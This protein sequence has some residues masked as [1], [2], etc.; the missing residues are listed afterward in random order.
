MTIDTARQPKGIPSGGQFAATAHAEPDV[1]LAGRPEKPKTVMDRYLDREA[2]QNRRWRLQQQMERLDKIQ[3]AHSLRSVAA[4]LLARYPDAATL[5][6]GEDP[7]GHDPYVPVSLANKD[8]A[9]LELTRDNDEWMFEEMVQHG[10]DVRELVA[11]LD[12]R[13]DD[14]AKDIGHVHGT[15]TRQSK[16]IDIDLRAALA[17]PD[18]F[19]AEE[20]DPRT[21][22]LSLDEQT[23]LVEA[24]NHGVIAMEDILD[25]NNSFDEHRQFEVLENLKDRVNTLLTVKKQAD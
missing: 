3:A 18:P 23:D 11:D 13:S 12:Y 14:W 25:D 2:V 8:G 24:A 16:M 17:A 21:R 7:D 1:A 15:G 9:L 6:I 20:H 4:L 10:T 22:T 5:R 19:I